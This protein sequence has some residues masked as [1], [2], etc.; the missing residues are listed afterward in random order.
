MRPDRLLMALA[1]SCSWFATACADGVPPLVEEPAEEASSLLAADA[2]QTHATCATY[3][4]GIAPRSSDTIEPDFLRTQDCSSTCNQN[5]DCTVPTCDPSPQQVCAT[6]AASRRA[7]IINSVPTQVEGVDVPG[8][9]DWIDHLLQVSSQIVIVGETDLVVRMGAG[10]YKDIHRTTY[11]CQK[12]IK[13]FPEPVVGAAPVCGCADTCQ[14]YATCTTYQAGITPR[15]DEIL[16]LGVQRTY[17]CTERCARDTGE[18]SAE[19]CS[20]SSPP[21]QQCIA[22]AATRRGQV[23]ASVPTQVEA[24]P[25]PGRQDWID[26]LLAVQ[27][28]AQIVDE[29]DSVRV[30][31]RFVETTH[32]TRFNCQTKITGFPDPATGPA[33]LC[34][35]AP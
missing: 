28:Q 4:L 26:H 1:L 25:V 10:F 29:T 18:C 33:P 2:C 6:A 9:Q 15:A 7:Q 22:L 3:Q 24:V 12:T 11:R 17:Q 13:S 19:T 32:R 35:C 23:I 16:E 20:A 31:G 34:G 21:E 27:G 14:A 8:R 30:V 5:E